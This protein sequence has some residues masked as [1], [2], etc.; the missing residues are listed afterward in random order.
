MNNNKFPEYGF[1][2]L[3]QIIAPYGPIPLSKSTWWKGVKDGKFPKST[4]LSA[5]VTVW[6][7]DEIRALIDKRPFE[8]IFLKRIYDLKAPKSP[9]TSYKIFLGYK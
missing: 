2:R 6:R 4:K 3:N 9:N 1:V 5:N 7:A 8:Q